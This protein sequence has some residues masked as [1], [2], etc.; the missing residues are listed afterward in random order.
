MSPLIEARK[1]ATIAANPLKSLTK[2]TPFSPQNESFVKMNEIIGKNHNNDMIHG[3]FRANHVVHAICSLYKMGASS[4][5]L[6][7]YYNKSMTYLE[8]LPE[9]KYDINIEN[10][11]KYIAIKDAYSSYLKF[12]DKQVN[13]L[14]AISA[15]KKYIPKIIPGLAGAALHPLIHLGYAVEFNNPIVAVEGLAYAY[16]HYL[17]L[18]NIIDSIQ[19]EEIS[20][21]NIEEKLAKMNINTANPKSSKTKSYSAYLI[22]EELK[23]MGVK[24]IDEE[25]RKG[26]FFNSINYIVE[27]NG[28]NLVKLATKFG[29]N[30][31]NIEECNNDLSIGTVEIFSGSYRQNTFDFFLLHGLT[32]NHGARTLLPILESKDKVR[33]LNLNFSALTIL[34]LIQGAPKLSEISK[35]IPKE[36]EGGKN[37]DHS[38]SEIYTRSGESLDAHLIKGV[39]NLY[40]LQKEFGEMNGL[41]FKPAAFAA[42]DIPKNNWNFSGIGYL[43]EN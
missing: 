9:D 17:A 38:W 13:E 30:K 20:T 24:A 37:D 40:E 31:D 6:E 14:G 19:P 33:L 1:S 7:Q 12:F 26:E 11:E 42:L 22:L 23:N 21:E 2:F 43:P 36:I 16:S 15:L 4:E 8:P 5:L 29:V 35:S 10:Y 39:R 32:G 41:F 27:N 25:Q 3:G 18:D 34:F 28:S